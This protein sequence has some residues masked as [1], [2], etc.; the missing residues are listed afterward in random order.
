MELKTETTNS[1]GWAGL[2]DGGFGSYNLTVEYPASGFMVT[3]LTSGQGTISVGTVSVFLASTGLVIP[4][5]PT[6]ITYVT[7]DTSTGAL[8]WSY[9]YLA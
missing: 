2:L 6:A 3:N 9:R 8:S 4:T 7:Y 5:Q 1:S